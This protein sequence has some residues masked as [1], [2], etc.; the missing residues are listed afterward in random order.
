M[1][2]CTEVFFFCKVDKK[3]KVHK[4]FTLMELNVYNR[5]KKEPFYP[6]D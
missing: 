3:L 4:I 5:D 2:T 6:V 1:Y